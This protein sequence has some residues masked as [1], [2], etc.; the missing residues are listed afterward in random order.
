MSTVSSAVD[1]HLFVAAIEYY[2]S[3]RATYFAG[4]VVIVG[5]LFH[6]A[7]E[8]LLKGE[9]S[10][11]FTLKE[12]K[13]KFS[14]SLPRLW[15][16]FRARFPTEVLTEFDP[17]IQGL[18]QF[19]DIRYPDSVVTDGALI[20]FGLGRG[21]PHTPRFS[22]SPPPPTYQ[23]GIGDVD[24]LFARVISLCRLNPLYYLGGLRVEKAR[25][26]LTLHNEFA[27]VWYPG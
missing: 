24:A 11:A 23:L 26:D 9:L 1:R 17:L 27:S 10:K 13:N 21:N 14:H 8:L 19:E 2:I 6:H 18:D 25:P 3:G 12:L 15:F 16:E 7:V 22:A 4:G 20:V 5:N